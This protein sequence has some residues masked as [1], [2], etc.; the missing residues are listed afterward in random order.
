MNH[1]SQVRENYLTSI[2]NLIQSDERVMGESQNST[3]AAMRYDI[4]IDYGYTASRDI[5]R[6]SI[7]T[8]NKVVLS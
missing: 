5:S 2:D 6:K 4:V 7:Y 8:T 3:G 1:F